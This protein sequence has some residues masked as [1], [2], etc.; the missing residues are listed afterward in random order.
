MLNLPN[1]SLSAVGD[2]IEQEDL[3]EPGGLLVLGGQGGR[4]WQDPSASITESGIQEAANLYGLPAMQREWEQPEP[5]YPYNR[6]TV[7]QKPR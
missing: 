4:E 5:G 2:I 1:T 6:V 3:L 7:F